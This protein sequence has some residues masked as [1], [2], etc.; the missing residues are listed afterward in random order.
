MSDDGTLMY[1]KYKQ[2]VHKAS[3]M[4]FSASFIA[5]RYLYILLLSRVLISASFIARVTL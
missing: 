4:L 1:R 5:I 2:E 3:R